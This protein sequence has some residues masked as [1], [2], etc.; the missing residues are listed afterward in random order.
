MGLFNVFKGKKTFPR[1]DF[2]WQTKQAK[3]QGCADFM[4]KNKVDICVAWFEDTYNMYQSVIN[5]GM[6]RKTEVVLAKT[7]LPFSLD[8]KVVLFL[9]H[10]PLYSKEENLIGKAK[11]TKVYFINALDD[12]LLMLFSGNIA[13]TMKKMGMADNE[14][15]EHA[16][17][18]RS[19]VN[20]QKKVE[21]EVWSDYS[22]KSGDDWI[23]QFQA[24]KKK[25]F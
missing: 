14:C 21:K 10:Y 23:R 2:T 17:I 13:Q 4:A 7:L 6:Q 20:A 15:L 11:P 22:A 1:T 18:S 8:N 3:L 9:E 24:N 16:M 19:I 12:A 5:K 25:A